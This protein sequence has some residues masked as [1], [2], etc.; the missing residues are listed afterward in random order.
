MNHLL[1]GSEHFNGNLSFKRRHTWLSEIDLCLC[2]L[3]CLNKIR[4]LHVHQDVRGSDRVP[5]SITMDINRGKVILAKEL[6][7]RTA[8]L[9]Q[10]YQPQTPT[11]VYKSRKSANYMK[12]NTEEFIRRLN[13]VEPPTLRQDSD[14]DEALTIYLYLVLTRCN[15]FFSPGGFVNLYQ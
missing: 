14:I 15:F 4:E 7:E 1:Y 6:V 5:I 2:K 12:V 9:G 3:T 10:S 13:R 8:T 11:F